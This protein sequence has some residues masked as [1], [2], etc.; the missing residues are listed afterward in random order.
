[1]SPRTLPPRAVGYSLIEMIIVLA[2]VGLMVAAM[3]QSMLGI[4]QYASTS[5]V[6]DD[7]NLEAQKVLA[8]IREDLGASGWYLPRGQPNPLNDRDDLFFPYV[9]AQQTG[10]LGTMFPHHDRLAYTTKDWVTVKRYPGLPGSVSDWDAA[11]L[12]ETQYRT[13]FYGEQIF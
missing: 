2:I 12:T 9:Q 7:L 13:S 4:R 10:K 11:T 8:I 1:M 5:E 3:L 6:Q